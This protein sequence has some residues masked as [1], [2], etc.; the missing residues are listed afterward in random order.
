MLVTR[1][2]TTTLSVF[3]ATGIFF[4]FASVA[5]SQKTM[6]SEPTGNVIEV[7][8]DER[9]GETGLDQTTPAV[10]EADRGDTAEADPQTEGTAV[11]DSA[12]EALDDEEDEAFDEEFEETFAAIADPLQ[13]FNRFM[14]EVNDKLYFYLLK[15]VAQVY[16][17]VLPEPVRVS[18]RNVI[19]NLR[20]P[21]RL[22]NC[23]LQGKFEGAA[24]EFSRFMV[25]TTAGILGLFDLAKTYH[26]LNKQ[27]EDFGQTLGFYGVGDGFYIIWPVLG[28]SSI[29]DTVG[30]AADYF[31]SPHVYINPDRELMGIVDVN[32]TLPN[33]LS[34]TD[35]VNETSLSIGKYEEFKESSIDPYISMRNAYIENRKNKIGK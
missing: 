10:K 15:P 16:E 34:A 33:V 3:L 7:T 13:P 32:S 6:P 25:N 24:I 18:V 11:S 5:H 22:V 29:R 9:H 1:G 2:K 28:P 21:V 23:L 35:I 17:Y 14:F 4:L 31:A 27:D 30:M 20:T 26:H 12:D 8:A 19:S